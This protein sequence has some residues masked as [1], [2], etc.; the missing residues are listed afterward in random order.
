M[1]RFAHILFAFLASGAAQAGVVRVATH[2]VQ[3]GGGANYVVFNYDE[4]GAAWIETR[5]SNGYSTGNW[6]TYPK[7]PLPTLRFDPTTREIV[8][9]KVICANVVSMATGFSVVSTGR[10]QLHAS[11]RD[12]GPD[13]PRLET[14]DMTIQ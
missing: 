2:P 6:T 9:G 14:I 3:M 11:I 12:L 5:D 1:R 13:S 7:F 10:C 4:T 8:F